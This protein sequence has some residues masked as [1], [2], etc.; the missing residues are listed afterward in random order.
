MRPA[1]RAGYECGVTRRRQPTQVARRKIVYITT[2]QQDGDGGPDMWTAW[3]VVTSTTRRAMLVML[4]L[5]L[6][7]PAGVAS[8]QKTKNPAIGDPKAIAAGKALFADSCASCHGATGEGGRGPNLHDRGVWHPL[9]DDGLFQT[10]QDGVP[11]ADMPPTKFSDAQLWQIVAFVRA[12]TAPAIEGPPSGDPS[13]GEA[14]FWA[15]GQCGDCH[16]VLGRGG[17][18]GPDL[19]NVGA[20]LTEAKLRQAIVDPDADGFPD[21]RGVTAV[22][23]DGRTV[24][25][26]ARNRSNYSVQ[27]LDHQGKLHLLSMGDVRELR[28]G[29]RSPM[30]G[31]Y[32]QRLTG[33]DITNLVAYLG[34]R[35]VRPYE[36]TKKGSELPEE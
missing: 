12:L 27:I 2:E 23:K 18:L 16:R 10:I 13:L 6:L 7:S 3:F 21:Y 36:R 14:V 34:R 5:A 20:T 8:G 29:D 32:L 22:L 35:S 30:A 28:L 31:D 19:S 17:L 4:S 11:G 9:D 1:E 26:V 24:T 33:E 15:K 25:G